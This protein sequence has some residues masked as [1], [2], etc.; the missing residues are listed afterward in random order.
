MKLLRA[1]LI[2][3]PLASL[4]C[5]EAPK[6]SPQQAKSDGS[7]AKA[8]PEAAP[9]GPVTAETDQGLK[10]TT[11]PMTAEELR[12][13]AADPKTLTRE[14][15][16][17]RGHALR[18]QI[19]MKPDSEQAKALNDARAAVLSGAV[20]PNAPEQAKASAAGGGDK[21]LVLQAPP[22]LMKKESAAPA[23]PA[24]PK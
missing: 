24:E 6:P 16:I 1:S 5:I 11:E 4:A 8:E 2:L 14:E 23:E 10:P 7:A 22:H 9:V 20:D 13:I 18:K 3:L 19:M 12:L 15:S 17:A 21:G